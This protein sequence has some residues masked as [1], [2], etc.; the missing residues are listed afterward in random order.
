M[1]SNHWLKIIRFHS[2][3]SYWNHSQTIHL[4]RVLR[5]DILQWL[6]S[7]N[8]H[9]KKWPLMCV[10]FYSYSICS[11][12]P[13][14]TIDSVKVL[15]NNNWTIVS[16]FVTISIR[17]WLFHIFNVKFAHEL[18]KRTKMAAIRF[19]DKFSK[20]YAMLKNVSVN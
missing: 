16:L 7:Y 8:F 10:F 4:L 20:V 2:F 19:K 14:L 17:N 18:S 1:F 11:W 3:S 15:Y 5:N 13:L 12:R 6:E 9:Y